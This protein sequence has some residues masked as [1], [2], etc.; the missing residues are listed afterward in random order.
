[1]LTFAPGDVLDMEAMKSTLVQLGY[2]RTAQAEGPGQFA[3][4]GGIL[5][6]YPLTEE[7]PVRIELWGDEIDSIRSFDAE[8][9]RSIENLEEYAG[10]IRRRSLSRMNGSGRRRWNGSRRMRR[11]RSISFKKKD[12][13]RRQRRCGSCFP[14]QKMRF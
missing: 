13:R 9:Q 4:R 5:D 6:V 14:M 7:N 1:M 3:I 2:E 12:R 11:E 8:S 10:S